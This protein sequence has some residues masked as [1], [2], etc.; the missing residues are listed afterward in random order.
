MPRYVGDLQSQRNFGGGI[1]GY[2]T[3]QISVR[4]FKSTRDF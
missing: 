4:D 3:F 1:E 2:E